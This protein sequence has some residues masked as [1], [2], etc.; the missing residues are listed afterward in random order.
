[1]QFDAKPVCLIAKQLFKPAY[2]LLLVTVQAEQSRSKLQIPFD[3]VFLFSK[4]TVHKS[5]T[6][7]KPL[8]VTLPGSKKPAL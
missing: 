2:P 5:A 6:Q 7:Q 1:M 8:L 4:V 3:A